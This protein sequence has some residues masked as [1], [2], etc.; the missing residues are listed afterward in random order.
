MGVHHARDDDLPMEVEHAR[1]GPTERERLALRAGELHPAS[2]H[3]HGPDD[4]PRVIHRVDARVGDDEVS[5]RRGRALCRGD[6]RREEQREGKREAG[7]G[8][9]EGRNV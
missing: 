8:K 6:G 4:G 9:Y 5:G 7:H 1:G 2:A 3:G